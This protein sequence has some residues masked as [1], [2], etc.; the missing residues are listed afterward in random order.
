[1]ST[2]GR[3]KRSLAWTL[4]TAGPGRRLGAFVAPVAIACLLLLSTGVGP[5]AVSRTPS[6]PTAESV[7]TPAVSPFGTLLG[8]THVASD[9]FGT[10]PLSIPGGQVER[11]IVPWS[12]EL[13]DGY[14]RTWAY[15]DLEALAYNPD[16][17]N[18][19]LSQANI[20]QN[21]PSPLVYLDTSTSTAAGMDLTISDSYAMAFDST[22]GTFYI[23]DPANDT[24]WVVNAATGGIDHASVPVGAD[25][26]GIAYSPATND[27]YVAN[28]GSANISVINATTNKVATTLTPV[29]AALDAV[30]DPVTTEVYFSVPASF[31]TA[32]NTTTNTFGTDLTVGTDPTNLT[33]DT[34]NGNVYVANWGSNS[35][36]VINATTYT[37]AVSA[38]S[39]GS[40]PD[41]IAYDP[42]GEVYVANTDASTVTVIAA[43]N[44]T[45]V[46]PA[47]SLNLPYPL[48]SYPQTIAVDPANGLVY[49]GS[50][51]TDNVSEINATTHTLVRTTVELN[52]GPFTEVF[53]SGTNSVFVTDIAAEGTVTYEINASTFATIGAP[54]FLPGDDSNLNFTLQASAVDP[55]AHEL[56][57]INQTDDWNVTVFNTTTHAQVT[58]IVPI[59]GESAGVVDGLLYDPQNGLLYES[60]EAPGNL[61]VVNPTTNTVV[62]QYATLNDGILSAT[63]DPVTSELYIEYAYF[64]NVTVFNT[65]T[66]TFT[67]P[68]IATG[69]LGEYDRGIVYDSTDGLIYVLVG[70]YSALGSNITVI[71][72]VTH[73]S[74]DT[75]IAIEGEPEY[76]SYNPSTD[77]I[78][79]STRADYGPW[80]WSQETNLTVISGASY[81][82]GWGSWSVIYT[83]LA[84]PGASTIFVPSQGTASPGEMW[85]ADSYDGSVLVISVP[86]FITSF[87][88]S[89]AVSDLG[90]S[91]AF[92]TLYEGGSGALNFSYTNLPAGCASPLPSF[93]CIPTTAGTTGVTVT[94]TDALGLTSSLSTQ[95]TVNPAL[96]VKGSASATSVSTGQSVS[97]SAAP[98]GGTPPYSESWTFGDGGTGSGTSTTHSYPNGGTYPVVVTVTDSVGQKSTYST[99]ISVASGS[100]SSTNVGLWEGLAAGLLIVGLVVGV[101]V[102]WLISHRRVRPPPPKPFTPPAGTGAPPTPPPGAA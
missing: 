101:A 93:T 53:D 25:P 41:G 70:S 35:V 28:H 27:V 61:T 47:I 51:N 78:Y 69:L 34:S 68:S 71:N 73:H 43:S 66:N 6:A 19:W 20:F 21:I 9:P 65:S 67:Y 2:G 63:L 83:G 39:V 44:N 42:S 22:S 7:G 52:G 32:L 64:A 26:T 31:V 86:P 85:A 100:S 102:G 77:L 30:Y 55:A 56:F 91:V 82:A 92:Q 11:T 99:A 5:T 84:V 95:V 80:P 72:P 88:A 97:F 15:P 33:V 90:Q 46:V 58:N 17:H 18:L 13:A 10:P 24:V 45:V 48:Y 8:S 89:P 75:G 54:M 59:G 60:Y 81:A 38:I 94:V 23:T 29:A 3:L 4:G 36:S 49:V 79:V 37:V 1:M 16:Q 98:A 57:L 14:H 76:L 74:I 50:G 87:S 96:T 12:G 40:G 62:H